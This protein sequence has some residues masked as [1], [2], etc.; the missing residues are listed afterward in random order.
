MKNIFFIL[1]TFSLD[2]FADNEIYIN[3]SGD[4][5]NLKV[6]QLGDNNK[7]DTVMNGYQLTMDVLQEGNRN[8]LLKNGT[9]IS[10]DGNTITTEQ[11]NNTTSSDVNKIY[12]DVSGNNNEID[13]GQGCKF[14]GGMSDTTC[15]R[16]THEDAGHTLYVDIQGG[17]NKVKGGQKSG[18]ANPNH[19]ASIDV[20]SDGNDVFYTQAG[21]GEKNL[22]LDINN[23][24]ND[25]TVNQ[26]YGTHTANITLNG[27]D[28]TTLNLTQQGSGVMNYTLTQNCVTLGG[29]SI[30]VTQQ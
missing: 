22:T 13:V 20:D 11:W 17:N 27:S 4:N 30:T 5:L 12:I 3:Q 24:S 21:S 25:V 10:G 14:A 28:S 7:V 8:E 19:N 2:L 18:T 15:D 23:D 26:L 9:G 1:M 6:R 16:D 29:C